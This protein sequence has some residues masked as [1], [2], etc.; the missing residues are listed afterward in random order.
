MEYIPSR[1]TKD[2]K[3]DIATRINLELNLTPTGDFKLRSDRKLQS[4]PLISGN[5]L[6]VLFKKM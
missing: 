5:F 1:T 4:S 6:L 3:P 2:T